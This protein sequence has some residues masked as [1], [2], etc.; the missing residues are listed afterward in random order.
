[1]NSQPSSVS[2]RS[3]VRVGGGAPATTMRVRPRPG[4]SPAHSCAASSTALTT[5][6]APHSSV[7]PWSLDPAQDLGTVDLAQ[8]D[9]LP[10]HAGDRVRHAPSVAVEHRQ[11]VQVHV[12]VAHARLPAERRGVDPDVAVR[13]LHALRARGRAARVVDRRGRVFVGVRPR[14][15]LDAEAV[16]L[17]VGRGAEH[18]PVLRLR[19]W[20]G[21]RRAR[22]RRAAS[23]RR[24]ARRCTRPRRSRGGS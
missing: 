2:T 13:H 18:E 5:A 12:A 22:D 15:G 17:V 11:R 6:G 14:F 20:R 4:I 10:A 16:E 8:H 7:T 23:T 9:V 3:I 1:M 19:P 24:S 21:S